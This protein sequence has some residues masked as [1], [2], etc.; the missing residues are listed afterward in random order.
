MKEIDEVIECL[1]E[2]LSS[3]EKRDTQQGVIT[4]NAFLTSLSAAST[5]IELKWILARLGR[6]LAGIEAHGHFTTG[7]YEQVQ[8]I[9]VIESSTV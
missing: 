7:E 9:R 6:H 3:A 1:T 4:F 8:R 2:L 5:S